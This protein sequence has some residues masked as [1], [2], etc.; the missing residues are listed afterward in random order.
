MGKRQQRYFQS[1]IAASASQLEGR[2][3]N[4]ILVTNEVF[5]GNIISIDSKKVQLK[6][7]GN[8][9]LAIPLENILEIITDHV[10]EY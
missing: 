2:Y 9:Q 5:G 10:A 8:H 6:D 3:V 7:Y 4:I 1:K